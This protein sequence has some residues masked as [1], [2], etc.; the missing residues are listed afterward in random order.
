MRPRH[1]HSRHKLAST[2]KGNINKLVS[3]KY[4]LHGGPQLRICPVGAQNLV[5][6]IARVHNRDISESTDLA[7]RASRAVGCGTETSRTARP[8]RICAKF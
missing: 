5:A 4:L 6:A 2:F 1:N 7:V 3:P 8:A